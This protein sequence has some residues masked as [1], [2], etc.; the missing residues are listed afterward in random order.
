MKRALLTVDELIANGFEGN[1]TIIANAAMNGY[2]D[3]EE[4]RDPHYGGA[5]HHTEIVLGYQN[6]Y[7]KLFGFDSSNQIVEVVIKGDC[8]YFEFDNTN[9]IGSR[10]NDK[11]SGWA[12]DRED[13]FIFGYESDGYYKENK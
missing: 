5:I 2:L 8:D 6:G 11:I 4:V 7:Y 1:E 9:I 12:F 13:S 10:K 3:N